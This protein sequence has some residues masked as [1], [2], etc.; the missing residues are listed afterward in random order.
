M[1]SIIICHRDVA[2]LQ[3]ISANI[4]ET[5]GVP[6]QLVVVDNSDNNYSIF[7]AYNEGVRRAEHDIL[8]FTHEDNLFFTN[9]WGK[10]VLQH[11]NDA[12]VGMI[13][14]NGGT[15]QPIVP[16]AWWYNHYF[17]K[18]ALHIV[19]SSTHEPLKN[20]ELFSNNPG[21]DPLR[22]EAVI[23]DGLWFCM[24]KNLFEHIRFDDENF[25]GFHLYDADI[26][27]Q[28]TPF[29]K[30][31]VV[32]DVLLQ[33]VWN[34]TINNQYFT[35]LENFTVKWQKHLPQQVSALPEQYGHLL[36]WHALRN[37]CLDMGKRNVHKSHIEKIL[38]EYR[39][40]LQKNYPSAWFNFY[41]LLAGII[42]YRFAN[43]IFYRLEMLSGFSKSPGYI[44]RPY[45]ITR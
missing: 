39:P 21:N 22:A 18:S 19:M 35:D 32:Y 6:Y 1:L 28:V 12:N 40:L 16:S 29:A 5:V 44:K 25:K 7:S 9:D 45:N 36:G 3:R 30:K 11:F 34:G 20:L 31:Y 33:H 14:N 13:G 4:A 42:G 43:S 8:C 2:L 17:G 27:M 24:R 10:K 23:I 26:S 37:V 15:A 38:N 41:F